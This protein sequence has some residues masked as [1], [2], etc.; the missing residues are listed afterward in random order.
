MELDKI[1][2]QASSYRRCTPLRTPTYMSYIYRGIKIVKDEEGVIR[3]YS[4]FFGDFYKE[5]TREQY[6]YFLRYGFRLGVYSLCVENYN[7]VL[8]RLKAK[9]KNEINGRNNQ[10][11]Y[12]ALRE[13]RDLIMSKYT[14]IINLKKEVNEHI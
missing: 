7:R 3:I 11:H 9:I 2:A 4:S 5:I 10:K 6:R 13:Y 14:D 1:W 12:N 8:E